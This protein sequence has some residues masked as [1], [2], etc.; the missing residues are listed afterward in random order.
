MAVTLGLESLLEDEVAIGVESNHEVLVAR[1]CSDG[2]ATSVLGEEL[3]E[4]FCDNKDLVGR[5]C[6]GRR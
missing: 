5:R 1:V 6:N 2:E 3:A 4:R